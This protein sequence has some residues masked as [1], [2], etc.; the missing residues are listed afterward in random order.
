MEHV[1]LRVAARNRRSYSVRVRPTAVDLRG[2]GFGLPSL[3]KQSDRRALEARGPARRAPAERVHELTPEAE[4]L[5]PLARASLAAGEAGSAGDVAAPK[6]SAGLVG[7]S[8]QG[9][10]AAD[11]VAQGS[12]SVG[13][14]GLTSNL[15]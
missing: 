4:D 13:R 6:G 10:E 2:G 12:G 8:I 11:G 7:V 9:S 1:R 15:V 3:S 14:A 5:V